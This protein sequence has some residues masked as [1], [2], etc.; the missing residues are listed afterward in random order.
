MKAESVGAGDL[1]AR[2]EKLKAKLKAEGLF[3]AER[4]QPIP[5][6]PKTIGLVTSASGAALQDMLN[7]LS[8]RAPP[9]AQV[10]ALVRKCSAIP[11]KM[12][13]PV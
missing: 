13:M 5:A 9:L 11:A 1:Q 6:H 2:L 7:V 10:W 3:E 8:R 4:K 12:T